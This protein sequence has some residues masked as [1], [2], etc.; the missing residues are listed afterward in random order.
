MFIWIDL[1]RGYVSRHTV[2]CSETAG[3]AVVGPLQ[4]SS[5]NRPTA[6]YH[7]KLYTYR[8]IGSALTGVRL[9]RGLMRQHCTMSPA[10]QHPVCLCPD[11]GFFEQDTLTLTHLYNPA[12]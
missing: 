11:Y 12:L 4:Q 5:S 1:Y 3:L 6:A 2:E 7:I 10:T 8:H 9:I